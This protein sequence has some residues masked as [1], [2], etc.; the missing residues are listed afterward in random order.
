[1]VIEL[2]KCAG[3]RLIVDEPYNFVHLLG[4]H[5]SGAHNLVI[6]HRFYIESRK[7]GFIVNFSGRC[8]VAVNCIKIFEVKITR[9]S[10]QFSWTSQNFIEIVS[11]SLWTISNRPSG[12]FNIILQ[13]S[14]R[15]F[16]W[17][18]FSIIIRKI[19][20]FN[21]YITNIMICFYR[22][23]IIQAVLDLTLKNDGKHVCNFEKSHTVELWYMWRMAIKC[24]VWTWIE[25]PVYMIS[26]P[27]KTSI[28]FTLKRDEKVIHIDSSSFDVVIM[29]ICYWLDALIWSTWSACLQNQIFLILYEAWAILTILCNQA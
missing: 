5:S 9:R 23:T 10:K 8:L 1:M 11:P 16:F 20:I 22:K 4:S 3:S 24:V 27:Y 28:I 13:A 29:F 12:L 17:V 25:L 21:S 2:S 7:I 6:S 14:A 19:I 15:Q 26:T 18:H